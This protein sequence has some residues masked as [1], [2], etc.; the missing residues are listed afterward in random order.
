ML[1]KLLNVSESNYYAYKKKPPSN[2]EKEDLLL[3]QLIIEYHQAFEGTLGYKQMTLF[4]NQL[5]HF[6]YSLDKITRL[7]KILG[8]KSRIRQS[9]PG[10]RRIKPDYINDNIINRVFTASDKNQ[11]WLSDVTE[12]KVIG[13]SVKVYL[14]AILDLYDMSIVS[15]KFSPRNNTALTKDV[16]IDAMSKN[17]DA[18]PIFHSDRGNNY[19]AKEFHLHLNNHGIIQSMSR[20]G[21]C[22]DNGPMEAFWSK[23]KTE[24]YY[25]NKYFTI[26][27]LIS[28]MT[29]YIEYYNHQRFQYKLKGMTPLQYRNHAS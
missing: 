12:F 13:T 17:P 28:D 16:F 29:K 26:P 6:T 3:A 18:K 24:K 20:P 15:Y 22:I 10:Y 7:M 21:K 5:N 4:I 9:K 25:L 11:K 27:E 2:R 14:C 1:C 23:V 19:T 8:V